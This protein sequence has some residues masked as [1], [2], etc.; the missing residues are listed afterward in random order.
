[1]KSGVLADLALAALGVAAAIYGWRVGTG[2]L[3][4][5]RIGLMPFVVGIVLAVCGALGAL[6]AAARASAEPAAGEAT[7]FRDMAIAVAAVIG[8]AFG[9]KWIG[10]LPASFAFLLLLF[11]IS[12]P[13]RP[14]ASLVYAG[15]V[16]VTAWLIFAVWFRVSFS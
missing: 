5:P 14:V 12:G 11:W 6:P 15:G 1:M 9:S 8:L 3:T 2:T 4:E 16:A 7:R 13:R 10:F